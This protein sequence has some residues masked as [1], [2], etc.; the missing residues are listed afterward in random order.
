M[1]RILYC[2]KD[3]PVQMNVEVENLQ[4]ALRDRSAFIWVDLAGEE[5]E[6]CEPILRET[7]GFHPLAVEDALRESH[8]PKLDEWDDYLYVVLHDIAYH[9]GDFGHAQLPELDIFLGLN[10]LV[11]HHH[12]P[13]AGLERLWAVLPRDERMRRN[14]PDRVLFRLAHELV[15][16]HLDVIEKVSEIVNQIEDRVFSKPS[17]DIPEQLFAL[18]RMLLEMRRTLGPQREVFNKLARDKLPGIDARDRILFPGLVRSSCP[19]V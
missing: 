2:P 1:I 7:F 17:P 6:R 10:F 11:T 15:K 14:G 12:R 8:G 19:F 9:A 5:A 3:K 16:D 4:A 18:K 13:M